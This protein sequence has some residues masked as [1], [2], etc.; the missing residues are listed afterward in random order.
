MSAELS[1]ACGWAGSAL[2]KRTAIGRSDG[3]PP[4]SGMPLS[5]HVV[6]FG[7]AVGAGE[8]VAV[9]TAAGLNVG[10]VT[11]AGAPVQLITTTA[12][13]RARRLRSTRD[14]PIGRDDVD[15]RLSRPQRQRRAALV[16]EAIHLVPLT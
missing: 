4:S 6:G 12:T 16:R 7:V 2:S 14:R 11:A 5:G 13:R 10:V 9:A 15:P 8:G 1:P 3:S